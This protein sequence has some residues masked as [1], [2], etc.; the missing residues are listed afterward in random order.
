MKPHLFFAIALLLGALAASA[1]AAMKIS[2]P[3]LRP[4]PALIESIFRSGEHVI[5]VTEGIRSPSVQRQLWRLDERSSQFVP[6]E[7]TDAG[8]PIRAIASNEGGLTLAVATDKGIEVCF[9]DGSRTL[10]LGAPRTENPVLMVANA[11]CAFLIFPDGIGSVS[12]AGR[13]QFFPW[14][15]LGDVPKSHRGPPRTAL[16][17]HD[18]LFLGYNNGEW[19]GAAIV[20]PIGP[21]GSLGPVRTLVR[22]NITAFAQDAQGTVWIATG[23][24]HLLIE[25]G[26]LWR[27][28]KGRLR[29][30]FAQ[31]LMDDVIKEDSGATKEARLTLGEVSGLAIGAS[32]DILLVA[33][34][35]GIV[36]LSSGGRLEPLWRGELDVFY[37]EGQFG[38]S[39]SP[40][41][42]VEHR[43]V[44]YV[45][46]RSLGVLKFVKDADGRTQPTMQI[47]F[48]S[49]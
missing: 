10:S 44:L 3:P 28:D 42:V 38:V 41:G 19:G 43:G 5:V 14:K 27:F 29:S 30:V 32:G 35:V 18:S 7:R 8:E 23:L 26:A 12:R 46:T 17:T 39:S 13:S 4:A 40:Q 37:Q 48:A 16:A 20:L 36:R 11:G 47:G 22:K 9:P 45:A 21:D 33:N 6:F 31:E 34:R 49:Q 24:S 25:A 1:Q 2:V 15:D